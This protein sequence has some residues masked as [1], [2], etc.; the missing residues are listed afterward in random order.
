M[1]RWCQLDHP[2]SGDRE[3]ERPHLKPWVWDPWALSM[4]G[5][6]FANFSSSL[7]LVDHDQQEGSGGKGGGMGCIHV[8]T[9]NVGTY[10][11]SR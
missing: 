9:C 1:G 3:G 10:V 8:G 11:G 5:V 7:G 6:I 2:C 4:L